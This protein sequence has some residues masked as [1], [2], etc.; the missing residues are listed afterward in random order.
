MST[1][2]ER[3]RFRIDS[4]ETPHVTITGMSREPVLLGLTQAVPE[5]LRTE[6]VIRPQIE[7]V[8]QVSLLELL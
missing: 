5:I 3:K 6:I 2:I 1:G 7:P 8:I 4:L